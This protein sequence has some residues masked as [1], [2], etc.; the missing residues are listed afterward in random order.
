MLWLPK[1]LHDQGEQLEDARPSRRAFLFMAA[2]TVVA[3]VIPTPPEPLAGWKDLLGKHDDFTE[4]WMRGADAMN[5]VFYQG[6]RRS[7]KTYLQYQLLKAEA[8]KL[9]VDPAGVHGMVNHQGLIVPKYAP[10][11]SWQSKYLGTFEPRWREPEGQ[12]YYDNT[13]RRGT[14]LGI[15]RGT[16]EPC[17]AFV[18]PGPEQF[19]SRFLT[20]AGDP[21]RAVKDDGKPM[22]WRATRR[23]TW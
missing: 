14:W 9:A 1:F 16:R 5:L 2:A 22:T 17:G 8:Q 10:Q 7:G 18:K 20:E 12:Q 23:R 13:D 3:A 19:E 11:E 6:G 21:L 15:D 4:A